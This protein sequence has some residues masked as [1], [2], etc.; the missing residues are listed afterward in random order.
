M[1][2]TAAARRKAPNRG[3]AASASIPACVGGWNTV[4]PIAQMQATDAIQLDNWIPRPGWLEPRRGFR[5]WCDGM[6][7][8]TPVESIMPYYG[9]SSSELYAVANDTIYDVTASGTAAAT[10]VTS[11]TSARCQHANFTNASNNHY[12]VVCNG[13]DSPLIYDGSSWA[14]MTISGSGLTVGNLVQPLVFQGRIFFVENNSTRFWY[15]PLGAISGTATSFELG[16]FMGMGGYIVAMASWT[17]DTRQSVD[18]YAAFITSR[19][20]VIVYAGTDPDSIYTWSLVG[21]YNLGPPVGRRCF[22]KIAGDLAIITL[23]GVVSMNQMLST[24]RAAANR[25]T[26][27]AKI[28]Q[29]VSSAI[30]DYGTNFGWQLESYPKGTLAILNVPTVETV[31]SI[32]FVMNTITGAWCRFI[33]INANVWGVLNDNI[34][35]GGN[36]GT[37]YQWDYGS[38]DGDNSITATLQAAFNYFGSRGRLKRFG[39]IRPLI[40]TDGAVTPGIGLNV[41]FGTGANITQPSTVSAGGANWDDALWDDASWPLETAVKTSWRAIEGVGTCAS[42]VMQVITTENG[43]ANG[44]LL[45]L[46]GWDITMEV[47]SGVL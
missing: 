34:F 33:G 19:G 15:L 47:S 41:D 22:L 42:V 21:I 32:Q 39:L 5:A 11:L 29:A 8:T 7:S 24:D 16:S 44:V 35:F 31:Q 38:G 28:M 25:Q 10:S 30:Q 13:A 36:D 23:D 9:V 46:N 37:I 4:S 6:G 14:N 40:T 27:S 3:Q 18:D 2:L 43:N 17:I 26:L 45:Q 12:L 20:Q 1:R